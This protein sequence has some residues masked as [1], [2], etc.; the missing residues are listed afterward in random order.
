M[1]KVNPCLNSAFKV[2]ITSKAEDETTYPVLGN[3]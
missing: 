3:V 2:V 1:S